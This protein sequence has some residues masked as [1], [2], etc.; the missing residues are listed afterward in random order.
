MPNRVVKALYIDDDAAL[1]RLVQ[2]ILTRR[3]YLVDHVMTAEEGLARVAGDEIDVVILDHDLGTGSGLDVLSTL[4]ARDRSPPVV[5]VTASTELSIA[6]EALKAGA[7]DYV[8]KTIGEDFEV[9]LVSAL[10]QSLERGR[11][12]R[13]KEQAE[14]E[15]RLAKERA[16]TLLAEVNH[17]VANSLALVGSLVRMQA[18][19]VTEPG[20]KAALAES[21]ARIT[22]IANLHRSLYTSV[23]VQKVDLAA[24]LGSLVGELSRSITA[25]GATPTVKLYAEPVSVKTDRAVS[26]GMIAT[27]LITNALKYAYPQGGGEV[28]V[29]VS[30]APNGQ[31]TLSVADDGVGWTGDGAV[32]G[33]GLGSKIISAMSKSLGA[34]LEYLQ[35]P[36]GTCASITFAGEA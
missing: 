25:A 21:Q 17:R 2:R 16:E 30:G 20:A 26:V 5:Y 12:T 23:D 35:Q 24:Y 33:S 4:S 27:E 1:G 6:V 10:E 36:V 28:R 9:L 7:A 32:R 13:A 15:M 18:A 11:L 29:S 8:V 14:L 19:A 22:A 34:P 31:I 3:G